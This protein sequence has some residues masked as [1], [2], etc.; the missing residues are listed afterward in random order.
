MKRERR[1][2]VKR[3]PAREGKMKG[4]RG[5]GDE[6]KAQRRKSTCVC[7]CMCVCVHVC[8]CVCVHVCG[9][10]MVMGVD[11]SGWGETEEKESEKK[12]TGPIQWIL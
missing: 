2:G 10:G 3:I 12:I 7:V 8:V 11:R 9:G 6:E 5:R 1:Q 4:G